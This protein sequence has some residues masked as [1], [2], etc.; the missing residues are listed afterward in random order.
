MQCIKLFIWLWRRS[1][2]LK[3]GDPC[4]G[5]FYGPWLCLKQHGSFH[6][7]H[8]KHQCCW[9]DPRN[10]RGQR[11]HGLKWGLKK[12]A[13]VRVKRRRPSQR[14]S[15]RLAMRRCEGA[16]RTQPCIKLSSMH[17]SHGVLGC[18]PV[19]VWSEA[20]EFLGWFAAV[21]QNKINHY[22]NFSLYTFGVVWYISFFERS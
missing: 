18:G 3:V 8:D 17:V 16:E 12:R 15:E 19:W 21:N 1:Q 2:V 13:F 4:S 5:T 7:G 9:L 6:C 22:V 11:T 20:V 14:R 10:I